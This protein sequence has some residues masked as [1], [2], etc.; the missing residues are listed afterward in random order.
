MKTQ[1]KIAVP[2]VAHS[3]NALLRKTADAVK[4]GADLIEYRLDYLKDVSTHSLWELS[5]YKDV[6][7]IFTNRPKNNE[8]K[9]SE[10]RHDPAEKER[11]GLLRMIASAHDPHFIDLE[12]ERTRYSGFR[13]IEKRGKTKLIVSHHDFKQTPSYDGLRKLYDEIAGRA[14]CDIVKIATMVDSEE[15]NDNI[16]RLI[17]HAS[18]GGGAKPIIAIGMGKLGKRTRYEGPEKGSLWTFGVLSI[19]ERSAPGQPLMEDLRHYW[20]TGEMR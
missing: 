19:D 7:K 18:S 1:Y 3:H 11:V 6:G 4:A 12:H 10:L 14:D 5:H 16:L 9:L 2:I 20:K 17:E 15:D 13:P 8:L